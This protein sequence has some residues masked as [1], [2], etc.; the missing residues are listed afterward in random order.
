MQLSRSPSAIEATAATDL[1]SDYTVPCLTITFGVIAANE[2]G[3]WK[4]KGA[5]SAVIIFPAFHHT[6][7][8][9]ALCI[10]G[11]LFVLWLLYCIRMSQMRTQVRRRLEERLAERE[12]IARD[13]HDTLLQDVQG[14]ILRFQAAT[15]R[16]PHG[17]P[18]RDLMDRALERADQVLEESRGQARELR[19]GAGEL[20]EALA[21]TA[22]PL[23]M[24]CSVPFTI[25]VAGDP[26]TLH[27]IV[28]E[29]VYLIASE[30]ISNA[31]RHATA[32]KIE[33][34]AVYD[35]TSL[36]VTIRDDG[37]G[38]DAAVLSAGGRREHSG[39]LGMRERA[40]RI[41][42]QLSIRTEAGKG[43]EVQLRLQADM[44]YWQPGD[45]PRRS[46]WWGIRS[47]VRPARR[48]APR[49]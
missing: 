8:F 6:S 35:D 39:L 45:V 29:E 30:A 42:G 46:P 5:S 23:S 7:S 47:L 16:I 33:L 22:A 36:V 9:Y 25:S 21:E 10:L 19:G 41:R 15:D 2:K 32:S 34:E 26:R 14:L 13:L 49:H 40:R 3:V 12:R 20:S 24:A 48:G 37:C 43:T 38:I 31:F 44:A 1:R 18:A 4:D 11:G 27:P 17:E 28:R